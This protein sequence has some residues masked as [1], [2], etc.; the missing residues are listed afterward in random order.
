VAMGG[1]VSGMLR[2]GG[3]LMNRAKIRE[4]AQGAAREILGVYDLAVPR[5]RSTPR[6][7]AEQTVAIII[8]QW[9]LKQGDPRSLG[10]YSEGR[11][12]ALPRCVNPIVNRNKSGVC[13]ACWNMRPDETFDH[14]Y[15]AG[16]AAATGCLGYDLP[17]YCI[18]RGLPP[19]PSCPVCNPA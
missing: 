16:R 8:E 11:C 2:N 15:G 5:G 6:N 18:C 3:S 1:S 9:F 12:C 19:K 4:L 13:T 7:G 10:P 14:V 17:P